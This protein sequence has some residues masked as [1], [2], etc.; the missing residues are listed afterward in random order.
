MGSSF[1]DIREILDHV[2]QK[3]RVAV[4]FDTAHAFGA[5]YDLRNVESVQRTVDE[6]RRVIGLDL[7]RVIHAN[8]SKGE[9]GSGIDR[10]EHIGMGYI[11]EEGFKAILHNDSLRKLPLIL[12]TPIDRRGTD[13]TNLRRLRELAS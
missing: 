9:L 8:D 5:G 1:E 3:D 10:H 13:V 12:E 4:C 11:G 7:L 6:L 2:S